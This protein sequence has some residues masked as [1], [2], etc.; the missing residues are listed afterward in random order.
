MNTTDSNGRRHSLRRHLLQ[1]LIWGTFMALILAS[2]SAS[3]TRTYSG[4]VLIYVTLG[5]GLWAASEVVRA[6]VLRGR[7]ASLSGWALTRRLLLTIAIAAAAIQMLIYIVL[8]TSYAQGWVTMPGKGPYYTP[9]AALLYWINTVA[10]LGLWVAVW[11]IGQSLRRARA[12]ELARAQV[13]AHNRALEL[14]SLKSRINPHFMF[15]AL[16]NLRALINEDTERARELVTRLSNTLRY[17]LYHSQQ[18]RVP[19]AEELAV[20]DDYLAVEAVHYED[21][22]CVRRSIEPATL[23]AQLPPMLLQLLVENA[24]KHGIACTPGGGELSVSARMDDDILRL[25]VGNPG[26]LAPRDERR[27][28]GL[29][30]LRACLADTLPG[31]RFVLEEHDGGVLARL[32]VPQ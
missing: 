11:M 30:Y 27:G 1:A 18:A 20:V 3:M 15:N 31:A 17:A 23:D 32:D 28:V 9:A 14:E 24:I 5:L 8:T 26:R 25:E 6:L 13:E 29:E 4:A 7:W 21:R 12:G 2:L 22:L 19:L 16:N 10:P